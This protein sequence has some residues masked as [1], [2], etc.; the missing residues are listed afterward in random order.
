[1]YSKWTCL[2]FAADHDYPQQILTTMLEKCASSGKRLIDSRTRDQETALHLAVRRGNEMAALA[3]IN[4]GAG[5]DLL[6]RDSWSPLLT[7]LFWNHDS[8]AGLMV[9]AG[10]SVNWLPGSWGAPLRLAVVRNHLPM[11]RMMLERGAV[12]VDTRYADGL[13]WTVIHMASDSGKWVTNIR[14]RWN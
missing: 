3:L 6:N 4:A 12:V 10:A 9:C 7:A 13:D 11:V 1:M 14:C 8:V 5:L 2:H